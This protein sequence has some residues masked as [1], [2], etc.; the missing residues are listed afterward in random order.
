MLS[1]SGR[2]DRENVLD[3]ELL[4]EASDGGTCDGQS[5]AGRR[6][7]ALFVLGPDAE[8]DLRSAGRRHEHA[9]QQ[10]ADQRLQ[11]QTHV[12][13]VNSVDYSK[14]EIEQCYSVCCWLTITTD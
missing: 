11:R 4:E 9:A 8:V 1:E 10:V 7:E 6:L 2:E 3:A 13:D 12:L 5:G 14:T